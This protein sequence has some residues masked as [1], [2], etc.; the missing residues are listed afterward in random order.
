MA[1]FG[2]KYGDIV[3]VVTAGDFSREFCGGTHVNSASELG[4]FK[5]VSESSAAAG[6]RR[7]EAVTGINFYKL[8][9][10]NIELLNKTAA[11]LKVN[12]IHDL[13]TKALQLENELKEKQKELDALN[14]KIAASNIQGLFDKAEEV[15]GV[16]VI[17]A[18]FD[19]ADSQALRTMCDKVKGDVPASVCLFASVNGD[20]LTF[21]AACGKDAIEKGA[22]AGNIVR[23][24]A[25]LTGG[26]GGGKPDSAMAGGKDTSKIDEALALAESTLASM[27]K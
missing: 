18:K 10:E 15:N 3:R 4:L 5:I 20:K 7:I 12:N 17:T 27:L 16:K 14:A 9:G 25:K 6:I 26:N 23:E 11:A 2:E 8:L 19:G 1:L 21:C 13:P 24:V 22:N